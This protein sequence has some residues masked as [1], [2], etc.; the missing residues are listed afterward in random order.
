[1]QATP[2]AL[3][4]LPARVLRRHG[5]HACRYRHLRVA[6]RVEG[7]AAHAH[8]VRRR[9][10]KQSAPIA[11]PAPVVPRKPSISFA[12]VFV[13]TG[14]VTTSQIPEPTGGPPSVLYRGFEPATRGLEVR[15]SVYENAGSA[16]LFK[17]NSACC[18]GDLLPDD[19]ACGVVSHDTATEI[20]PQA[21]EPMTGVLNPGVRASPAD[22]TSRET[23]VEETLLADSAKGL[24]P[25][26]APLDGP[27]R[28][29][30][31]APSVRSAAKVGTR[32]IWPSQETSKTTLRRASRP[33]ARF[34]RTRRP[35]GQGLGCVP[36]MRR[37]APHEHRNL[38]RS[39]HSNR[40]DRD[41]DSQ[42]V[43]SLTRGPRHPRPHRSTR[44]PP[45]PG[46]QQTTSTRA[47][48]AGATGSGCSMTSAANGPV[49]TSARTTWL[50][51]RS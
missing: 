4:G 36:L 27:N 43:A 20:S 35:L 46:P 39:I 16:D 33:A 29:R 12:K 49:Q 31:P 14:P 15:R 48:P 13:A 1:M 51:T 7:G 25:R 34:A 42:T 37:G 21:A 28:C 26:S 24:G 44:N 23:A 10:L 18:S 32:K 9:R 38:H 6:A 47:L 2:V 41:V 17:P 30:S 50:L 19:S 22:S 11:V 8:T 45:P 5:E 3:H 40:V